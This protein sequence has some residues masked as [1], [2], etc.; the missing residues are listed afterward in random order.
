VRRTEGYAYFLQEWGKHSWAVAESS[1]ITAEDVDN[2]SAIAVAALDASFFGVRAAD[3]AGRGLEDH[4][5][6]IRAR[7]S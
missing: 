5:K 1:P 4:L 6:Q 2:A 7:S 3:H